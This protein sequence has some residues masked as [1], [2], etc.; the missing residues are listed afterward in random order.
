MMLRNRNCAWKNGRK[1]TWLRIPESSNWDSTI[2][3]KNIIP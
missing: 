2:D 3:A 1:R